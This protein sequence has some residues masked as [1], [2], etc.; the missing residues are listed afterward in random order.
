MR[1]IIYI[2][3]Y[4]LYYSRLRNTDYKWLD[5]KILFEKFVCHQQEPSSDVVAVKYFTSYV[6]AKFA[7]H[8]TDSV[9]S[10]SRYTRA[11]ES[12]YPG[13]LQIEY[14][15]HDFGMGHPLLYLHPP[16]QSQRVEVW[17]IEEKQTD[18]HIATQ[19]YRDASR[20]ECDQIVLCSNDS[21]LEPPL[22]YIRQ[23]FPNIQVGVVIPGKEIPARERHR[24]ISKSL[25]RHAHWT[26]KVIK[27]DEMAQSQLPDRVP[28]RKKPIDKPAYW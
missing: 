20:G 15:K 7:R 6:N 10:Q 21:D 17:N 25:S 27:N 12:L 1:T 2:D 3:G 11:L 28:T 8:G 22:K 16:D 23:D 9:A 5:I 13:L 24:P 26:R 14:S 19:M 18:V 4:N